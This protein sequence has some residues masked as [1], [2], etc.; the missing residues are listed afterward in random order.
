[1][2]RSRAARGVW[3]VGFVLLGGL[4]RAQDAPKLQS[5]ALG[6]FTFET[7]ATIPNAHV[8]YAIWGTLNAAKDN[9][10]LLPSWYGGRAT[11]YQFLVG[12]GRA[13]DPA[14][15]F[16]VATE[17]FGS[18]GSS[19]PSNTPA[20]FDGPRFPRVAIRD[21]VEASRRVLRDGLG[22]R[23]V[24][25]VIGFSMGAQQAF[26]WAASHPDEVDAI[27]ALCGTAKTYPHGRVR[28]QSAIDALAADS[29]WKAGDYTELPVDGIKAWAEHW[30]AWVYSQEWWRQELFKP[31]A[32]TPEAVL[33]NSVRGWQT[34]NLN[35]AVQLAHTWQDHDIGKTKRTAG[36]VEFGGDVEKALRSI[37]MP[38]L[39]MP[40]AT[41]L[42]F[43]VSD[44]QYERG[45]LPHVTFTPI[46]SL[47]GHTAGGGGN[48]ADAA[49][50]NREIAKFLGG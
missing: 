2:R 41:D 48:P 4:A 28:L 27:V 15:Y 13:L 39:Y 38:V 50:I 31:Q 24:R 26:Q 36:G 14:R 11:S 30:S 10:V 5:Y 33:A 9:A 29:R 8:T 22:V 47:W 3:V 37:T 16:I 12:A 7:G 17:M 21:D 35:D 20:P 25:A 45:F 49:F 40:G 19:S 6:S 42:Y 23:H 46:P 34:R 32:A 18:G 1:M 44:A 43:P